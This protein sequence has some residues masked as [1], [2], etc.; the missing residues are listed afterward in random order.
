MILL[1]PTEQLKQLNLAYMID[2]IVTLTSFSIAI[3]SEYL[4]LKAID[5][6]ISSPTLL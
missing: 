1:T 5:S 2:V 6:V 3:T 4:Q